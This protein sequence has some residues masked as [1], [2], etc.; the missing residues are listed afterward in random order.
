MILDHLRQEYLKSICE[1]I[2]FIDEDGIPSNADKHSEISTSLAKK[3]VENIGFKVHSS[4]K[5][6]Q[7]SGRLFEKATEI[8]LQAAL[9]HLQHLRPGKWQ[10]FI[11]RKVDDFEQYEHLAELSNA[12]KTHKELRAALGDYMIVPDIVIGR[13]PVEDQEINRLETLLSEN[14]SCRLTPFRK[15]NSQKLILHTSISCKWT[16]RSDR[17]Q[18][19]RTEGLNLIRNRKGKTPHIV[20][21]TAEPYPQRIASLALGTGDIDCVYHTALLELQAAANTYNNSAVNEMLETLVSGKRL[22]DISDLPF[23]LIS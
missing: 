10:F 11:G 23:D 4:P 15:M 1:T 16:I 6:G 5:P 18:N 13:T 2:L 8:Y 3:W 17:S 22:R 21:V 19:S 7:T 12:L 14:S 20:I 9:A